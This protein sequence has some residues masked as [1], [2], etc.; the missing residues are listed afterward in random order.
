MNAKPARAQNLT[1]GMALLRALCSHRANSMP[2]LATLSSM[3]PFA[4]LAGRQVKQLLGLGLSL[5]TWLFAPVTALAQTEV[6]PYLP[7]AGAVKQTL[8][9][10]PGVYSAL[11][12]RDAQRERAQGIRAGHAEFTVRSSFQS[13]RAGAAEGRFTES[14]ISVERPIRLWGKSAQ[15]SALA[16]Q[17]EA[18]AGIE[19]SDA[20]HEASR[21]LLKLWFAHLRGLNDQQNA[22][23]HF[24]YMQQVQ[25]Q[26]ERR[27][28]RGELAQLDLTLASAE[29]SR[30]QAVR[31]S[32]QAQLAAS[33]ATLNRR[34]PTLSIPSVIPL[35][36]LPPMPQG[37]DTL[38]DAFLA[39]N[40]ELN[41][42]RAE[43]QRLQ[44]LARRF[45]LERT[46]DPTLGVYA[47]TERG[48]AEQISGVSL[49]FPIGGPIR[50]ANSRMAMAEARSLE[51]Q[52]QQVERSLAG[53]F[54]ALWA[55]LLHKRSAADNLSQAA[56][57]QAVAA[58]KSL[59]AFALGEYSLAQTL[60][61]NRTAS[62][63]RHAARTTQLEVIELVA[64]LWLDLHE[65]WDLD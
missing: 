63:Y 2:V 7:D 3:P 39:K 19:Y 8:L 12:K 25:R 36:P 32:A 43:A 23:L 10:S 16:A 38:R 47:A 42:L 14:I 30:A 51:E 29:L 62:E 46:P 27:F 60:Q 61:V 21:E 37:L 53:G 50:A 22:N 65:I 33:R 48:G 9:N 56:Q 11:A 44:L 31:D 5:S 52:V 59:R 24:D 41:L 1:W 49:S 55:Q 34:Y 18:V 35:A 64:L 17:T 26:V 15:D 57:R 54:D 6:L 13:R 28:Q 58:E 4:S 20:L 45:E 40:H